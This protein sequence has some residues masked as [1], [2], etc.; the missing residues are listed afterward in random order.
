[1]PNTSGR[2]RLSI[3]FRTVHADDLAARRGAPNLDS[4]CTGTT[5]GDYLRVTDL[6]H[7]PPEIAA[8][9]EDSDVSIPQLTTC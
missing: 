4:H 6:S 5:I 3:D 2:T 1:V 7:V 8:L 9:Y